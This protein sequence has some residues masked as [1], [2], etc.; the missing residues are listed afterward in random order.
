MTGTFDDW[1]KTVQL[2]KEGAVFKKTVE[3]PQA[4]HQYKVRRPLLPA[5][6]LPAPHPPPTADAPRTCSS[7]STATG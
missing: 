2:Q 6:Q 1:Q 5:L 4:K 3:L 7:S